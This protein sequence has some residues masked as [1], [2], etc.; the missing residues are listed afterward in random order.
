VLSRGI[1]PSLGLWDMLLLI[2]LRIPWPS[3]LPGHNAGSCSPCCLPGLPGPFLQRCSLASHSYLSWDCSKGFLLPRQ[4]NLDLSLLNFMIFPY[5]LFLQI[6]LVYLNDSSALEHTIR[7]PSL[8]SPAKLTSVH[9]LL[10]QNVD[11]D[12][13]Q[14]MFQDRTLQYYISYQH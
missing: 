2:Q 5:I 8:V 13:K 14:E 1:I 3:L 12:V 9:S 6:V 11:E 10:L 7:S 4:K